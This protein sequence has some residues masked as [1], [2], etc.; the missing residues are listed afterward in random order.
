LEPEKSVTKPVQSD[1]LLKNPVEEHLVTVVSGYGGSGAN[2]DQTKKGINIPPQIS[3]NIKPRQPLRFFP[4]VSPG[5]SRTL[6]KGIVI[7]L[8]EKGQRRVFWKSKEKEQQWVPREPVQT[9]TELVNVGLQNSVNN[10]GNY[11]ELGKPVDVG[12]LGEG[13][14][15]ES[16]PTYEAGAFSE[17]KQFGFESVFKVGSSSGYKECGPHGSDTDGFQIEASGHPHPLKDGLTK[18]ENS[19]ELLSTTASLKSTALELRSTAS[20]RVEWV[21]VDMGCR[22]S[23][24]G[25]AG[26]TFKVRLLTIPLPVPSPFFSFFSA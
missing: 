7:Q 15:F 17:K 9:K 25:L 3:A 10:S 12:S 5:N 4:D 8:N 21:D 18:D 22:S 11:V 19:L 14:G 6:G 26:V 13:L 2:V 20:P 24:W 23:R 1:G 16:Q